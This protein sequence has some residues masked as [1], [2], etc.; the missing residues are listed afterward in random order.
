[1]AALSADSPL[2]VEFG[3]AV[4]MLPLTASQTPFVGS[5]LV[6]DTTGYATRLT[7]TNK[8]APLAGIARDSVLAGDWDSTAADGEVSIEVWSGLFVAELVISGVAIDD[9]RHARAV[10]ATDEQT[11]SMTDTTGTFV[12]RVVGLRGSNALV[13]VATSGHEGAA[14]LA[15]APRGTRALDATGA[16]TLT[17]A[18]LGKIL[19]IANTASLVLTLPAAADCA[20][21]TITIVK[22][23]AGLPV[24]LDGNAS[25][26]VNGSTTLTVLNSTYSVVTLFCTGAAWLVVGNLDPI[27]STVAASAAVTNTVTET[28]F[29]KTHTILANTLKA[30]DVI[31]I[32]AQAIAS[33]TH[34]DA[35]LT[36]KLYL[37]AVEIVTTGAVNVADGDIG[38][39]DVEICIRTIGASGTMVAAGVQALGVPGTVT[40]KPFLLASTAIDTTADQVVAVKATWSYA[41][42]G[43]SARLDLLTCKRLAA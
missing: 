4:E 41:N 17:T 23:T 15:G 6:R 9:V 5:L 11:F 12:G 43:N 27:L 31:R 39:V 35:T 37:N 2:A 33:A 32:R 40:A 16:Q 1:M 28:G 8:G 20:G 22:T 24:T 7:S 3:A 29:D 21:Q 26:T 30:G 10:F 14:L 25:E 38:Y 36:L 19:T 13:L 34:S 18:D 42:A